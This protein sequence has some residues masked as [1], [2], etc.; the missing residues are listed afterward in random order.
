M[1]E[2]QETA[3]TP[4]E[5]GEEKQTPAAEGSAART[6]TQEEVDAIV[7][8]RLD[9][10]N[11]KHASDTDELERRIAELEARNAETAKEAA[12]LKAA[13]ELADWQAKASAETG[14]PASLLRGTTAEEV[15]EHA[16]AIKAAVP[17]APSFADQGKPADVKGGARAQFDRFMSS[18]FDND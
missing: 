2:S 1:A 14:V 4:G 8:R 3:P 15:M 11:G 9:R 13:K 5:E 7:K 12:E 6:F 10:L 16:K 18:H 17:V